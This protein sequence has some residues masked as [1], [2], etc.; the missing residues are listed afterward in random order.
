MLAKKELSPQELTRDFLKRAHELNPKLNA[1]LSIFE[2]APGGLPCAIKDAI[3]VEGEKCTAGSKILENYVAS[4][5][6]TVVKKLRAWGAS[7]LGKANCDEFTMGSTGEYSAFGV[8]LNPFDETRVAGG[9][10]SG[11]AAAVAAE[12]ALFSLG[13]DTGGSIR[14]PAAWCGVVGLKPTYGRV[15]RHGEIPM[16]S[17]LDQIGPITKTVEDAAIVMNVIAGHDPLDSTSSPKPV[18]DYTANLGKEIKNLRVAVVKEFFGKGLDAQVE[19]SV[20]KAIAQLETVGAKVDEVSLPMSD[21]ALAAYYVIVPSEVSANCARYDGIRYGYSEAKSDLPD[22][23]ARKRKAKNLLEVYEFSRSEGFGPEVQRRIMIG[24]YALSAG[25]YDAYYKKAQQVRTL[26]RQDF[27]RIFKNYDVI[28]GPASATMAPKV[29]E[30][31][32]P[33]AF[34][35]ADIYM[36]QANLA[37]LC[38]ISVP[39]GFGTIDG[40]KL[41][42]GLQIIGNRF[43]EETILKVA[44][45]YESNH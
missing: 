9:S 24:T 14:L 44:Y 17:S 10:S 40:V 29:G 39:C 42:I 33:L 36:I 11:S 22:S 28:V 4:Y 19:A 37:G 16:A 13:T 45:I 38:A 32:N 23:Q 18:P 3:M 34:Y 7:I 43:Q 41:P 15:S 26:I 31:D 1:Y 6:A 5:N 25:Y 21:Y 30:F 8:T 2:N 27:D 35:L 20:K 12:M